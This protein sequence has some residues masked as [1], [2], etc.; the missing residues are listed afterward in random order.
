MKASHLPGVA[1]AIVDKGRI[2]KLA[3]NGNAS[4]E[5][6]AKVDPDRRFQLASATKLFTAILLMRPSRTG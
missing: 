3:G 2:T 1:I 4:L 6:P 5:W